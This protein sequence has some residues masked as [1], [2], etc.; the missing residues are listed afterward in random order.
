[1]RDTPIQGS[2]YGT[3]DA[4]MHDRA[5]SSFQWEQQKWHLVW[6]ML[7]SGVFRAGTCHCATVSRGNRQPV[8]CSFW[9]LV[10]LVVALS[11][12]E[13]KASAS[14]TGDPGSIP[15]L[16]EDPLE[17]EMVTQSSILA[18]RIP[19]T[20]NPG[21]L[22]ST[23][24]QRVGHDWANSPSPSPCSLDNLSSF[25]FSKFGFLSFVLILWNNAIFLITSFHLIL[26]RLEFLIWNCKSWLMIS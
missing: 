21:R 6:L 22:Q 19:W 1:M 17:K 14:N 12:S 2:N 16:R 25:Q 26:T 9:I 23:S 4:K 7:G 11:G 24:S 13:V 20:E 10:P 3:S 8:P 5:W 15:G 18:W